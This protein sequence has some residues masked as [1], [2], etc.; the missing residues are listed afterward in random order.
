MAVM[1][2]PANPTPPTDDRAMRSSNWRSRLL[3]PAPRL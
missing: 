3:P 1:V 2:T